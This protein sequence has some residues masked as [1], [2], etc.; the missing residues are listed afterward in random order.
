MYKNYN[1]YLIFYVRKDCG[2]VCG[3]V[4]FLKLIL[5]IVDVKKKGFVNF[6]RKNILV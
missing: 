3:V 2:C 4:V 1:K 5:Y 6:L